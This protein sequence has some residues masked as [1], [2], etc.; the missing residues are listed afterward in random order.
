MSTR[1]T[2][3][4]LTR[5]GALSVALAACSHDCVAL[6]CTAPIAVFLTVTASGS[7][8]SISGAV[9]NASGALSETIP[10]SSQPTGAVC[11]IGGYAG[12]YNLAVAAPGFQSVMRTVVVAGDAPSGCGCPSID[13]QHI[14]IALV[15]TP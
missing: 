10:C 2:F 5:G 6:P 11:V 14:S 12:T 3:A 15:P 1:S 8:A 7:S 13:T 9:V 4:T